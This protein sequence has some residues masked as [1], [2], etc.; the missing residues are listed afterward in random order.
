MPKNNLGEET[1][2][3]NRRILQN[4]E[5]LFKLLRKYNLETSTVADHINHYMDENLRYISKRLFE[6]YYILN[7]KEMDEIY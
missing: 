7:E 4:E 6:N 2:P 5:D 1:K 3:K